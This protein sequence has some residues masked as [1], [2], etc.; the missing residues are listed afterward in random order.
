MPK[1]FK[2]TIGAD[3]EFN[4]CLFNKRVH[5]KEVLRKALQNSSKY[6]SRDMGFQFND[7]GEIGWDGCNST[8]ELRPN[9]STDPRKVASNVGDLIKEIHKQMPIMDLITTNHEAPI[10]GHIH[11]TIPTMQ[12]DYMRSATIN[13]LIKKL[14]TFFIPI[15]LGENKQSE[16]IRA[17]GGHYGKL[18]DI[19]TDPIRLNPTENS[20]VKVEYRTPNAEWISHPKICN[21]VLCYMAVCWH[22]LLEHPR[23]FAKFKDV[24][25]TST[26]VRNSIQD[27]CLSNFQFII[28]QLN[29]KIKDA[30]KTFE[31]YPE[32]KEEIDYIFNYTQVLKDKE[33]IKFNA[34]MGWNLK[35]HNKLTQVIV[36]NSETLTKKLL[37]NNNMNNMPVDMLVPYNDDLNCQMFATKLASLLAFGE[38]D[39]KYKYMLFGLRKGVAEPIIYQYKKGYIAGINQVKTSNDFARIQDVMNKMESL[40]RYNHSNFLSQAG[41]IPVIIIGLPYEMRAEDKFRELVKLIYKIEKSSA[42][43]LL[44]VPDYSS[45]S[46]KTLGIIDQVYG[47][48]DNSNDFDDDS[49]GARY[50]RQ[51]IRDLQAVAESEAIDQEEADDE[52]TEIINNTTSDTIGAMANTFQRIEP[53]FRLIDTD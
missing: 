43:K 46:N 20:I 1:E 25:I 52:L 2:F 19:H 37:K 27:L 5:A 13:S 9:F 36:K 53:R 26:D 38:I 22:Q 34:I 24:M 39:C 35:Q 7:K 11:L 29:N 49:Q 45:V 3:P 8:G 6:N 4:L 12:Y 30:V 42:L 14:D 50:A 33:N 17:K 47:E 10:G 21:A 32:Y 16:A 48:S 23:S 44:P 28:K 15:L 40:L 18:G 41:E 31:M 51:T